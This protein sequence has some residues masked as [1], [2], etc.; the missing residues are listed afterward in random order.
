MKHSENFLNLK[1]KTS[2]FLFWD[3]KPETLMN[4]IL[5]LYH[6][7][8]QS[9]LGKTGIWYVL[10]NVSKPYLQLKLRVP[11]PCK[12]DAATAYP[13]QRGTLRLCIFLSLL[14]AHPEQFNKLWRSCAKSFGWQ[15]RWGYFSNTV[16]EMRN[17]HMKFFYVIEISSLCGVLHNKF[18][19]E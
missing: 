3:I 9:T 17:N 8:T 4:F 18:F 10:F 15:G 6:W 2:T 19:V 13:G 16:R 12:S 11:F 7:L 1:F 14:E 5:I